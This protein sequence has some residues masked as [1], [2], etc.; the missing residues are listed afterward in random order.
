METAQNTE[1][2]SLDQTLN[3]GDTI[4]LAD[5]LEKKIRIGTI[6]LLHKVRGLL[7]AEE[8]WKFSFVVGRPKAQIDALKKDGEGIE[9]R[10]VD[11]PAVE[12][13]YREFF[14]EVL[15]GGL[16]DEEYFRV[17]P[18]GIEELDALPDR[19]L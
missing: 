16:S 14:E 11:F 9:K 13:S 7:P 3:I 8:R 4:R 2:K 10:E 12:A 19:F 5:G 1:D 18:K 17:D 6:G 15:E